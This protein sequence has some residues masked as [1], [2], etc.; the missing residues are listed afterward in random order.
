MPP[1]DLKQKF[2]LMTPVKSAPPLSRING[3]GVSLYGKRDFDAETASYVATWCLSILFVPCL[4]LRAYRVAKARAAGTSWAANP[5]RYSPRHGTSPWS[6]Q[7]SLPPVCWVGRPIR[8]RPPTKPAAKWPR[9]NRSPRK[10]ILPRRPRSI[11]RYR[12]FRD[13]GSRQRR[14]GNQG[15]DRRTLPTSA[16]ASRSAFSPRPCKSLIEA[17]P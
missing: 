8:H 1:I 12:R 9:P 17:T 4:G 5:S 7:F 14:C 3:C 6:E 13:A 16:S 10:G 15:A 11:K 2:P